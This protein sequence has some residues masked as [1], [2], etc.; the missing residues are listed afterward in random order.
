MNQN[1]QTSQ[2]PSRPFCAAVEPLLP[3][4]SLNALDGAEAAPVREHIAACAFCQRQVAEFNGLR[5]A[6]RRDDPHDAS[7]DHARPALSMEQILRRAAQEADGNTSRQ[8][9]PGSPFHRRRF[10]WSGWPGA[11][12]AVLVIALIGVLLA[13][14]HLAGSAPVVGPKPTPSPTLDA[15]AQAYITLLR[16]YYVPMAYAN[17]AARDCISAVESAHAAQQ[18]TLMA[19]CRAP[20][21][22]QLALAQV[23]LAHLTKATPPARWRTQHLA[24]LQAVQAIIAL[25]TEQVSAI[26]AHDVT[27]FL[28]TIDLATAALALFCA[29]LDQLDLGPPQLSPYLLPPDSTKCTPPR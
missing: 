23:L 13:Q 29:P 16:T 3:L 2:P 25:L 28:N 11:I 12:A 5:D 24:L 18:A 27:R 6:L 19:T 20:M 14:Q 4:L 8:E 1:H 17:P 7:A 21:A 26:D 9:A 15:T 22:A 10:G